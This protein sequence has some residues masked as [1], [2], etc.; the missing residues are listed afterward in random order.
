MSELKSTTKNINLRDRSYNFSLETIWFI[1]DVPRSDAHRIICDQLLRAA[2]SIGANII[3]AKSASSRKDFV[4]FYE[5]SLK[6]ANETKYWLGL[7]IDS[8]IISKTLEQK[9]VD[10]LGEAGEL[11]KMLGSSLLTLKGKKL[12]DFS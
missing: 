7:L 3:E 11:C 9:A 10:L 8:G 12:K 1:G 4:K 6:S 5:I 2:T